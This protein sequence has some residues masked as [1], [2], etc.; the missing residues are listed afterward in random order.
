MDRL[1]IGTL[2][3]ARITRQALITPARELPGVQVT[4]VAARNRADAEAFAAEHGIPVVHDSYQA[5]LADPDLDAVYNPLPN[6]LHGLWTLRAIAAGKHVLCEKPFTANAAEA[7]VVADAAREAGLVVMEAMHYRYHLLAE[8]MAAEVRLIAGPDPDGGSAVRHVHCAVSFPLQSRNDIRYSC[9]L[10]GGAT[11]DAGCY[12]LDLIRLLGPG[13]PEVVSAFC[14][15]EQAD[16]DQQMTAFLTF[17]GGATAWLDV[18]FDPPD[19]T[20]RADVHV[21]GAGGQVRV[22]NFIHPHKGYQIEFRAPERGPRPGEDPAPGTPAPPLDARLT[23]TTYL[24]QLE[25]FAAAVM[26]GQPFPT[27]AEHAVVTMKLIDDIYRAAGLP[28]R[29]SARQPG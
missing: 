1:R 16:V 13:E 3:A 22:Q 25:A 24:G 27:T 4:A 11:M 2:G 15:Q 28:L 12:A 6:S 21:I 17:P 26:R 18:C 5:L 29:P 7:R 23:K 19:R 10:A 9:E 8:K 14:V 20:F